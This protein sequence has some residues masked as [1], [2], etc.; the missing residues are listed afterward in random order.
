MKF[1]ESNHCRMATLVRHFGD[2]AD[3]RNACGICDFCSPAACS[4]QR[5]RNATEKERA[6]LFRVLAAL[7]P[8][9]VKSTGKLH[10]ELYPDAGMSRDAFEEVLGAMSRA[11][12]VNLVD[13]VFEKDGKPIPYR[14]VS[15]TRASA[16]VSEATPVDLL[17][18]A[19][20]PANEKPKR[21][22]RKKTGA[23][24]KKNSTAPPDS[25]L[26]GK[27]RAWRLA[28]AKR[29][30]VP[31]FRIF[32]DQTLRALAAERPASAQELLSIPGIGIRTVEQHGAQI[33]RILHG[34]R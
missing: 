12:L 15:L 30:G 31:A 14:K 10:A 5:F 25:N 20:I 22:K 23:A 16:A 6:A 1:A 18:K 28:E 32:S 19:S 7:R 33:Y 9:A 26:E 3:A 4:A 29:R 11:G 2:F 17:I 34:G 24:T 21:R 27:L 8:N 13:A